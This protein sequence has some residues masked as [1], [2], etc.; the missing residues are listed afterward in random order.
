MLR[1][2]YAIL[3]LVGV[4]VA[5][6]PATADGGDW[7]GVWVTDEGVLTLRQDGKS[8]TGTYGRGAEVEAEATGKRLEG[9]YREGNVKGRL[10]LEMK[11]SGHFTGKWFHPQGNTGPWRGWRKD[12]GAESKPTADFRGHWLTSIGTLVLTQKGTEV[13]GPWR[14]QGWATLKGTVKGRR[15]DAT[16]QHPTWRGKVSL[17]LDKEGKRI[18]G[19]TDENP[20]AA[21]RGVRLQG[22]D[23]APRLEAGKIAQGV[24]ENGMLYFA[25]PPDGWRSGTPVD[26]IVLLHGS[27][28]TT[29]GMVWVTAKNW[30]A[31]A[32]AYMIVGIQGEEWVPLSEGE[33][34]RFNYHYVNWT[35]RSTYKGFPNTERDSPRTVA[36][37]VGELAKKHKWKRV[38][39]GG[40]S[41][42]GFLTYYLHMHFPEVFAGAFPMAGGLTIQCEPDVFDDK[43][44]LAL[45]RSRPLAIVHGSKDSV[46]PYETA[47]YIRDRFE[48]AGFARTAFLDPPLGHPYDFLPV[49]EAIRFLD[50][51]STTKPDV[52]AAYAEEEAKEKRWHQVGGALDRARELKAEKS[53]ASSVAAFDAAAAEGAAKFGPLLE[54]GEGGEWVEDF[55]V[56]KRQFARA[57]VAA[58]L[59]ARYEEIRK[60]HDPKADALLEEA[61]KAVRANDRAE[62]RRK[63]E[64]VVERYWASGMYPIV[65]RWLAE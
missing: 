45:Q 57:P 30:P 40:H 20:P 39:V 17:E 35:G 34:H 47:L 58:P 21:V 19:Q 9:T 52:L 53:L 32:K 4:A 3:V 26:A 27:N 12:D 8:V 29:K 44:L 1:T 11:E 60:E 31:L 24:A 56:W 43:D 51:M 59:M 25:R 64:E 38:F 63:Y 23:R 7:S 61:R 18:F 50:A 46:V 15:L 41:Q 37:V 54:K 14:H 16:L 55:I 65:R 5:A 48:G 13:E 2:K 10:E 33:D 6:G 28:W 62:A 22:F 36:D 49:G 42:G